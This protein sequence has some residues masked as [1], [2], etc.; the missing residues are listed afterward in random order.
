MQKILLLQEISSN[1]AKKK[2]E[3]SI[4]FVLSTFSKHY[5][6]QVDFSN[7]TKYIKAFNGVHV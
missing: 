1:I 5:S 4:F 7:F 3:N 2:Y 6:Y